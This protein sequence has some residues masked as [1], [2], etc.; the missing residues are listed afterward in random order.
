MHDIASIEEAFTQ[1]GKFTIM[2]VE[3]DADV[4]RVVVRMLYRLGYKV[5]H[6]E[7]GDRAVMVSA[8]FYGPIDLLLTDVVMPGMNGLQLAEKLRYSRPELKVLY[9]S[10]HQTDH[11]N[12]AQPIPES[13]FIQKPFSTEQLAA[14]LRILLE[15]DIAAS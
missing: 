2:V 7:S 12:E 11:F 6:A 10:G 3:D 15:G 5:L 8:M 9:M 13:V 1:S 14:R 4:R